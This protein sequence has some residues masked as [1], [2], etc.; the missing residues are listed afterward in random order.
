MCVGGSIVHLSSG[1]L[2]VSLLVLCEM[3]V[4][5]LAGTSAKAPT[6]VQSPK[7]EME[8][9]CLDACNETRTAT[10]LKVLLDGCELEGCRICDHLVKCYPN[11]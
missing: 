9:P 7:L 11:I 5:K 2:L 10:L 3:N 8:R 4:G 6:H 1:F